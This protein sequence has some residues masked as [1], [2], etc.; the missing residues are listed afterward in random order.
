MKIRCLLLAALS[1]LMLSGCALISNNSSTNI[2]SIDNKQA[3]NFE[4]YGIERMDVLGMVAYKDDKRC[5]AVDFLKQ[6]VKAYPEAD[7]VID[8]TMEETELTRGAKKQ[9]S[10]K[11]SGLAVSYTPLNLVDGKAWIDSK[12]TEKPKAVVVEVPVTEK[13]PVCTPCACVTC[14]CQPCNGIAPAGL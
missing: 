11:Y 2:A 3:A 13:A 12:K 9:F 4:A 10:C 7:D 5:S 1:A 6:A 14:G 8:V